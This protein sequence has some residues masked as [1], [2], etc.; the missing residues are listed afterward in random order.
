MVLDHDPWIEVLPGDLRDHRAAAWL[1]AGRLGPDAEFGHVDTKDPLQ[2][3]A[4]ASGLASRGGG[5]RHAGG[6]YPSDRIPL[7]VASGRG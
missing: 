5:H 7:D 1:R 4:H 3:V 6:S 2:T